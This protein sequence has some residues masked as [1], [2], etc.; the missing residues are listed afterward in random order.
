MSLKQITTAFV[1][2]R[3]Q[4]DNILPEGMGGTVHSLFL[5]HPKDG[6]H[7]RKTDIFVT[8]R[9][10]DK[11]NIWEGT[12]HEIS[13][14]ALCFITY[15][16]HDKAKVTLPCTYILLRPHQYVKTKEA[17]LYMLYKQEDKV[18]TFKVPNGIGGL[19][20]VYIIQHVLSMCTYINDIRMED[21][22]GIAIRDT[23]YTMAEIDLI[24]G[25]PIDKNTVT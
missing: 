20:S 21:I 22:A 7:L 8:F 25:I 9:Q 16:E 15:K 3:K 1:N 19:I 14:K 18:N 11:I 5:L 6:V 12:G 23:Y 24:K 13:L 2:H 10:D 4:T 17:S